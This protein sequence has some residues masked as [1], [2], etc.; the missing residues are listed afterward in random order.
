MC[1]HFMNRKIRGGELAQKIHPHLISLHSEDMSA[2]EGFTF[3]AQHSYHSCICS[4][5]SGFGGHDNKTLKPDI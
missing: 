1:G 2:C 5:G 4:G 3:T